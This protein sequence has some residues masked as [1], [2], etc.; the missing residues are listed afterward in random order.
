MV[1]IPAN[2]NEYIRDCGWQEW[3]SFKNDKTLTV[4]KYLGNTEFQFYVNKIITRYVT[5][6]HLDN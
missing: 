3:S 5:G 2:H 1:T 4:I 6:M